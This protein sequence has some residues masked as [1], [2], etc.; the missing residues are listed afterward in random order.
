MYCPSMVFLRAVLLASAVL[1]VAS[2]ASP[3]R[4][5]TVRETSCCSATESGCF[6]SA[7]P[8]LFARARALAVPE[9]RSFGPGSPREN[10]R[11]ESDSPPPFGT[12]TSI[13]PSAA[14]PGDVNKTFKGDASAGASEIAASRGRGCETA[15]AEV[16]A[17]I[18]KLESSTHVSS[19]PEDGGFLAHDP[20]SVTFGVVS[21]ALESDSDFPVLRAWFATKN[22]GGWELLI[23]ASASDVLLRAGALDPEQAD[24][25]RGELDRIQGGGD[26]TKG[27]SGDADVVGEIADIVED[28]HEQRNEQGEQPAEESARFVQHVGVGQL[29]QQLWYDERLLARH[30]DGVIA[31]ILPPLLFTIINPYPPHV[32]SFSPTIR[33]PPHTHIAQAMR[34]RSRTNCWGEQQGE[35]AEAGAEAG[36]TAGQEG[37]EGRERRERREAREVRATSEFPQC[38][39]PTNLRPWSTKVIRGLTC[40]DVRVVEL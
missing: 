19:L 23:R 12:N 5:T 14:Q 37:Q 24:V 1:A 17:K 33:P 36:A 10:A 2:G 34:S 40:R 31:V 15:A 30:H 7:L 8:A 18:M 32:P 21:R 26:E 11:A 29:S 35:R 28:L 16:R 13:H 20:P 9:P 38:P 6:V 27:G 3:V 4:T 22:E 25:H 39:S